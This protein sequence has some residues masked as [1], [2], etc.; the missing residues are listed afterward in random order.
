MLSSVQLGKSILCTSRNKI[1]I[2][3]VMQITSYIGGFDKTPTSFGQL[4][5]LYVTSR[6]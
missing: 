5:D 6:L 4:V 1:L 3:Q 2:L